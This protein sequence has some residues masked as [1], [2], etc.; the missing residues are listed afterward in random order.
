MKELD[1][2]RVFWKFCCK[3]GK[4]IAEIFQLL[5]QAYGEDCR[6]RTHCYEWFK[7]FKEGRMSVGEIPRHEKL[8]TSKNNYH[9]E[10]IHA[11]IRGNRHLTFEEFVAEVVI[12][13][14]LAIKFL[15]K[16]FRCVA[17][18]QNSC[19]VCLTDEMK[20]NRVEISQELLAIVNCNENFLKNIVT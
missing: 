16:K 5:N 15:L 8:S 3:L 20:E 4:N 11:V 17:S 7:N 9:V 13:K 1:E 6:S 14:F 18:V 2:Q 12:G 10:N 19:R